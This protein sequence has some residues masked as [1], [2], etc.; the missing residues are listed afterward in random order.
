[1]KGGLNQLYSFESV[2]KLLVQNQMGSFKSY[3]LAISFIAITGK[4]MSKI[5]TK[6]H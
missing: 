3:Y 5:V 4:V 6:G 2:W 1:M